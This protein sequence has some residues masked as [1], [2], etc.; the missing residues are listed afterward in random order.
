M[1]DTIIT[2]SPTSKWALAL[3][4]DYVREQR[5]YGSPT[6]EVVDWWGG[7]GYAKY[8]SSDKNNVAVRYEYYGDPQGHTV[9]GG[10]PFAGI[11][12]HD[13]EVTATFMHMLASSLMTRLEYRYDFASRPLFQKGAIPFDVKE[14]QTVALG[15]VY[16]F[17]SREAK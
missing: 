2:Y 1:R 7:G 3:N 15:M 5:P 11:D 13:Q 14:R 4:G 17:D 6:N 16:I 8:A 9:F 12:P 10:S